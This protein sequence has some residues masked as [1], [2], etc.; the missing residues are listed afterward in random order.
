MTVIEFKNLD[1]FMA[2]LAAERGRI[3]D[4]VVRWEQNRTP[5]SQ[6]MVLFQVDVWA[7]AIKKGGDEDALLEC[8]FVCGQDD[9]E[10]TR[11]YG[12]TWQ[13]GTDA[14]ATARLRLV[15]CCD[16]LELSLRA[17]KIEVY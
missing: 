6:A 17:G 14:A 9:D 3:A 12:G 8:G 16:D 15:K 10:R 1:D 13:H 11:D 2:E 7:T 5:L 4:G